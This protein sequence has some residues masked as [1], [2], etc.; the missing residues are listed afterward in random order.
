MLYRMLWGYTDDDLA[1]GEDANLVR[2]LDDDMLAVR[3]LAIWN[4]KDITGLAS[5]Y[6]RPED[7]PARRQQPKRR[8]E[9]RLRATNPRAK[10]GREGSPAGPRTLGAA[11]SSPA[12]PDRPAGQCGP[13]HRRGEMPHETS[14]PHSTSCRV[15]PLPGEQ[16]SRPLRGSFRPPPEARAPV[17]ACDGVS[18]TSIAPAAILSSLPG[19]N[20]RF[21]A[22]DA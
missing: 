7:T 15:R 14:G 18:S 3:V 22:S 17:N 4:L 8:W 11:R 10:P 20:N 1:N 19:K 21:T 9:E 6:Y 13:A 5:Q 12:P 2:A 16:P